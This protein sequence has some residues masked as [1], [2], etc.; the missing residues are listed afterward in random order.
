MEVEGGLAGVRWRSR[1]AQ[2]GSGGGSVISPVMEIFESQNHA[3][4]IAWYDVLVMGSTY[5]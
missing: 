4:S 1:E 5:H 2:L 3:L